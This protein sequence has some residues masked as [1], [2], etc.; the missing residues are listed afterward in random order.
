M[1]TIVAAAIRVRVPD[2]WAKREHDCAKPYP[3]F[4]TISAPPPARHHTLLHPSFDILGHGTGG[5]DQGFT[6]S[7]GRYVGRAEALEIAVAAGQVDP[8]NRKSGS[9]F[10]GLFSEDL[11]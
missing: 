7:I 1:E 3:D 9:S 4:L 8:A 6:T 5:D 2:H 11:W 10:P